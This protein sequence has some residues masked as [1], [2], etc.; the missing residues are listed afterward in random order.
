MKNAGYLI[1]EQREMLAGQLLARQLALAPDLEQRHPREKYLEDNQLHF[2]YLAEALAYEAPQLFR[3]YVAWIKVVSV[4]R[5]TPESDLKRNLEILLTVLKENLPADCSAIAS[6]LVTSTLH[7]F[8]TFPV[9]PPSYLD[10]TAPLADLTRNFLNALLDNQKAAASRLVFSA[11]RSGT[12][13]AMIYQHVF[14]PCLYEIGRLWQTAQINE[15]QEHFCAQVIETTMSIIA[16]FFKGIKQRRVFVGFCVANER[17]ELGIRILGDFFE[18]EGWDVVPL[19]ANVPRNN[20][21]SILELWKPDV[22]GL[23]VTM[24]Y[25]L[26]ELEA[27]VKLIRETSKQNQP[28]VLIGGRPFN[29][30][31]DLWKK[32]GA[33][34]SAYNPEQALALVSGDSAMAGASS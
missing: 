16:A 27:V 23:S 34:A 28:K 15:A 22:I 25:H 29:L 7:E 8:S 12:A 14:G 31:P 17:H 30:C 20:V 26:P 21:P 9:D 11:A 13:P 10:P 19:G 33:D 18:I 4:S 24:A 3:D 6:D 2:A 5:G 32:F 1:R